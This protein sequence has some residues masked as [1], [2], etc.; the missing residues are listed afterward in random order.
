MIDYGKST[1]P[2]T[3]SYY[4]CTASVAYL[5]KKVKHVDECKRKPPL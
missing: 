3:P 5:Y 4:F 1:L 2:T